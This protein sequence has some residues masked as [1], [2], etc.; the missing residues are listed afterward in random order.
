MEQELKY[1]ISK[2]DSEGKFKVSYV[3][4]DFVPNGVIDS[5]VFESYDEADKYSSPDQ[6][7]VP[8]IFKR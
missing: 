5:I 4:T 2:I 1:L 6:A 8:I 3:I 7:I